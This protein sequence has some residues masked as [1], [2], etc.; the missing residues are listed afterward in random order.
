MIK[1]HITVK[2]VQLNQ[3]NTISYE[4][5]KNVENS[6]SFW[7]WPNYHNICIFPFYKLTVLSL[8]KSKI[9]NM[10]NGFK[11]ILRK[12][13]DWPRRPEVKGV[14]NWFFLCVHIVIYIVPSHI[15]CVAY[16]K[17]CYVINITCNWWQVLSI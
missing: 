10:N 15:F 11:L 9:V 2:I 17:K 6:C 12:K 1:Q 14:K 8:F 7:P 3:L 5:A 16:C 13:N 4:L